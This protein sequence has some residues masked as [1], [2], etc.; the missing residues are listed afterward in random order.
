MLLLDQELDETLYIWC[1]PLEVAFRVI[2][3]SDV[4]L[5]EEQARI[6]EWPVVRNRELFGGLGLDVFDDAFEVIVLADELQSGAGADA[7]DG[8]EVVAAEEDTE[9]NELLG[10]Q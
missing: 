6:G 8:I 7:L 4:W 2:S 1:F 3:R 9:V 5:E 10:G